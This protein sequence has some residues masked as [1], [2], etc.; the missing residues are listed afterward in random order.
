MK[1]KLVYITLVF[2]YFSSFFCVDSKILFVF[3]GTNHCRQSWAKKR[4][5]KWRFF[6]VIELVPVVLFYVSLQ[7]KKTDFLWTYKEIRKKD[8]FRS[9]LRQFRRTHQWEKRQ[10][11]RFDSGVLHSSLGERTLKTELN[12]FTLVP[13]LIAISGFIITLLCPPKLLVVSFLESLTK[14]GHSYSIFSLFALIVLKIRDF[15]KNMICH[16]RNVYQDVT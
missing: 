7:R 15:F 13:S 14:S 4:W 12:R 1:L 8:D 3:I 10:V 6:F 16:L 11:P 5:R 2:R 9:A